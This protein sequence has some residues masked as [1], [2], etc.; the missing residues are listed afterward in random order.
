[1]ISASVL[2]ALY[3]RLAAEG[4]PHVALRIAV[5]RRQVIAERGPE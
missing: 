3:E 5:L 2:L 1:M 4:N